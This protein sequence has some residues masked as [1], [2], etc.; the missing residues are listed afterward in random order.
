[1][2][3]LLLILT[4]VC[5]GQALI[6]NETFENGINGWNTTYQ[7]PHN[8]FWAIGT[9]AGNGPS[10]PGSNSVFVTT[11]GTTASY[12]NSPSGYEKIVFWKQF[13]TTGYINCEFTLSFDWKGYGDY[14]NDAFYIAYCYS[15]NPNFL[16]AWN[17]PSSPMC[18]TPN[19]TTNT[20]V[21][22]Y[23]TIFNNNP[24]L[25][26]GI[27][28]QSSPSG[29]FPPSFAID[30]Y[31]LIANQSPLGIDTTT[32]ITPIFEPI[33]THTYKY[34][35][36]LGHEIKDPKGLVIRVDEYGNTNKL[37]ITEQIP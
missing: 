29:V 14:N 31:K 20:W 26:I 7:A 4:S 13:N 21:I 5:N 6:F 22:G 11:D 17:F 28:F 18:L 2:I 16:Y 9:I 33:K 32:V 27:M 15:G 37:Y 3:Y 1:M 19:W 25:K 34:Y 12:A 10:A 8:N 35:N 36:Y 24:A 23:P 30:N